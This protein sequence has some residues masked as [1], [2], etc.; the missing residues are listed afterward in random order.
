VVVFGR[1]RARWG[2]LLLLVGA[3]GS[4]LAGVLSGIFP[5]GPVLM[6]AGLPLG[7]YA[8]HLLFRHYTDRRLI[9]ANALTIQLHLLS[10]LLLAV[11]FFLS[12]SI[13]TIL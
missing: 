10:G 4:V 1:R 5:A 3:F 13:S 7:A 2:Y 6:L 12:E 11:G 8:V 9:R